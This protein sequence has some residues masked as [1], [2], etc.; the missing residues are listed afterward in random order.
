MGFFVYG[1]DMVVVLPLRDDFSGRVH[2]VFCFD[3]LSSHV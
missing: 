2:L 3:S 1:V